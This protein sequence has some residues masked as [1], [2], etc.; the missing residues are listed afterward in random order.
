[1]L[2][3]Q[4]DTQQED[5]NGMALTLTQDFLKEMLARRAKYAEK[6][7]A[8]F[9]EE[10]EKAGL[11]GAKLYASKKV[12]M[13]F[14]VD[15]QFHDLAF[16]AAPLSNKGQAA[17]RS[18]LKYLEALRQQEL[19][20]DINVISDEIMRAWQLCR[21]LHLARFTSSAPRSLKALA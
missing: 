20:T 16:N 8:K 5:Q 14:L 2:Q 6:Q 15:F 13:Q 11:E 12:P 4:L 17:L 1:M 9:Q 19:K 7:F 10:M 18:G 3:L 21:L